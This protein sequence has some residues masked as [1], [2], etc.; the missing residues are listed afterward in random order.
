M[1]T[2]FGQQHRYNFSFTAASLRPELMRIAA[3]IFLA[4]DSWETAKE[5]ILATNALQ[6]Q[7]TGSA[8]RQERELRQRLQLLTA[9]QLTLLVEAP[10]EDRAAMAWLA[11]CKHSRFVFDFAAM[12]VRE[13]LAA[14]DPVLR[15]SDYESFVDLQAVS[16]PEM[17]GL[18]PSSKAK[19]RQVLFHMLGAA[20]LLSKGQGI[21][22]IHRPVL[23]PASAQ[24][25]LSDNPRWLAGFLVP[26]AEI[27]NCG[28]P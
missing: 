4:S 13:K 15:L 8:V 1:V 5:R 16:H 28:T 26:D 11:A 6:C 14:N 19:I 12:V 10:A 2:D 24:A 3:E 22:R 17:G 20:G 7:S 27:P 21:G 18:T 25:I 23:S 9:A